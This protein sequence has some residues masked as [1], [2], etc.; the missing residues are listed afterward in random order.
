[1]SSVRGV[2]GGPPKDAEYSN[3]AVASTLVVRG[4][5]FA[6]DLEAMDCMVLDLATFHD[7]VVTGNQEIDGTSLFNGAVSFHSPVTFNSNL[8]IAGTVVMSV[9]QISLEILIPDVTG[10][11]TLSRQANVVD[12]NFSLTNHRGADIPLNA[13]LFRVP[14]TDFPT[15]DI[16]FVGGNVVTPGN[17]CGFTVDV[18]SG[19][20]SLSANS[21]PFSA[22]PDGATVQGHVC[23]ITP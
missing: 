19:N 11:V 16:F 15:G 6:Q 7:V 3:L 1:M 17:I 13:I 14:S 20:V 2:S 5:V 4:K 10:S 18:P 8:V 23:Y 12:V 21:G 22:F 9:A